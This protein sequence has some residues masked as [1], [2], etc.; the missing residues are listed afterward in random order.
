LREI[1]PAASRNSGEAWSEEFRRALA[2]EDLALT[3]VR[4]YQGDLE[5]FF[6]L[7]RPPWHIQ[8]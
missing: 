3:T 8:L 4:A 6:S 1:Q 7:V 2:L 5:A